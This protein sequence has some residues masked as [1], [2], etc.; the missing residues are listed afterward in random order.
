MTH[1]RGIHWPGGPQKEAL[2]WIALGIA[3]IVGAPILYGL[4]RAGGQDDADTERVFGLSE[5]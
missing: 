4:L 5:I 2:M 1:P 3:V